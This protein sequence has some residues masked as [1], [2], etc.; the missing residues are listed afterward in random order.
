VKTIDDGLARSRGGAEPACLPVS[1]DSAR[2]IISERASEAASKRGSHAVRWTFF[3]F[4]LSLRRPHPG[5]RSSLDF[6]FSFFLLYMVVYCPASDLAGSATTVNG[7]PGDGV[8]PPPDHPPSID[9]SVKCCPQPLL[10]PAHRHNRTRGFSFT[11]MMRAA[12]PTKSAHVFASQHF[13][14]GS[15][16]RRRL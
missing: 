15:G 5:G 7:E 6:F 13:R 16:R 4:S 10:R 12:G 3:R 9:R 2:L 1:T 8:Y 14:G 11:E